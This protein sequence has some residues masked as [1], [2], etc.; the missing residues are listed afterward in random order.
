ML[1]L[2]TI[3]VFI[4]SVGPA[5]ARGLTAAECSEVTQKYGVVPS[6]CNVK[7]SIQATALPTLNEPTPKMRQNNI[8]FTKGGAEL[9]PEALLQLQ[10]LAQALDSPAM[11]N[12]CIK[13]VGHSDSTGPNLSNME[14]AANRTAVVRNRL[15]LLLNNSARIDRVETMGEGS[16]LEGISTDSPWQRRVEI[17]VRNCS[18][19]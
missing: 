10:R 17:W 14:I 6:E 15:S 2:I 12:T 8:F 11:Q 16:P 9:G 4:F 7:N 18:N 13:L 5:S 1:K 19:F 3:F